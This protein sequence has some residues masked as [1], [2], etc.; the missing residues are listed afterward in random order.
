MYTCQMFA[1]W[2]PSLT[3]VLFAADPSLA[4]T[5]RS[6]AYLETQFSARN[7][8]PDKLKTYDPTRL[9]KMDESLGKYEANFNRHLK[10][11]LDVLDYYA[12][13]ETVALSRLCAQLSTAS[14]GRDERTGLG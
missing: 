10:I 7:P 1:T 3:R 6:L 12:A 13:T 8:L 9:A 5:P 11:F 14:E 4:G 2:T